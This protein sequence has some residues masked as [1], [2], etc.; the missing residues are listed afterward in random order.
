MP[1]TVVRFAARDVMDEGSTTGLEIPLIEVGDFA[2]K[3]SDDAVPD[4]IG[5][6][7]GGMVV[8]LLPTFVGLAF[9]PKS[10]A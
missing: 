1:D 4:E 7:G 2:M 6:G 3:G 10:L 8:C 9:G 5:T